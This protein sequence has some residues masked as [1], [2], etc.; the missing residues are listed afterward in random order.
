MIGHLE[1]FKRRVYADWLPA[2]GADARRLHD[3]SGFR[4][5][6]IKITDADARDFMR[7]L[8]AKIVTDLGGGR[9]RAAMSKAQ[10]SIFWEGRKASLPRP[11]TLWVEPVVTI[12][13]LGRL[14]FDFGWPKELLGTQ[15]LKWEFDLAAYGRDDSEH[16]YLAG[17]VK[18]SVRELDEM[19][20]HMLAFVESSGPLSAKPSPR[21]LNAYKK[22]RGLLDRK[23]KVFWAIAP[24]G[25]DRVFAIT[26]KDGAL[27]MTLADT[28]TLIYPGQ[29]YWRR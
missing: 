25:V 15:S 26:Y 29:H 11:I 3:C 16:E 6:S 23:A 4:P 19:I 24:D 12:A 7:S 2:Y 21:E 10:E 8:D 18:K 5:D 1:E 14:H 13:A 9:Y 22:Y 17:E 28:P 20:G 27:Q